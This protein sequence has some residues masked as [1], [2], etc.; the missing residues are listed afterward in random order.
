[1]PASPSAIF[2]RARSLLSLVVRLAWG[3]S[4]VA[5][6]LGQERKQG[7]HCFHNW[8]AIALVASANLAPARAADVIS[9]ERRFNW[10]AGT[11]VGV[12]GGFW[13]YRSRTVVNITGLDNT[14]ATDVTSALQGW[15]DGAA[16]DVC[17]LLPAGTFRLNSGINIGIKS[18]NTGKKRITLRGAGMGQTILMCYGGG[19]S[20]AGGGGWPTNYPTAAY[21]SADC[22]AGSTTMT[23]PGNECFVGSLLN[24]EGIA[25]PTVPVWMFGEEAVRPT[26]LLCT[27]VSGDTV[28][29]SPAMP[30]A[31]KAGTRFTRELGTG[32]PHYTTHTY[33]C[34]LEDLTVD[35]ANS[36]AGSIVYMGMAR[37]CWIYNVEAKSFYNYGISAT[38]TMFCSIVHTVVRDQQDNYPSV[39]SRNGCLLT[40]ST[41]LLYADNIAFNMVSAMEINAGMTCSA[42]VYN[43]ADR[44]SVR[45]T[46]GSAFNINHGFNN[47][48]N[49]YEG[50]IIPRIQPDGYFGF[51][52]FETI[53]R[54]WIHGTNGVYTT[55]WSPTGGGVTVNSNR[56]PVTLNRGSRYFNVV[57]NILGRT[58]Q[59][60]TWDTTNAG[61]GFSGTSTTSVNLTGIIGTEPSFT[62]QTG[63]KYNDNGTAAILYSAA[64]PTKWV[65]GS[66]RSYNSG[67]GTFYLESV[68]RA[69]GS[70]T[71]NDWVMVGGGGYGND[72]IYTLGGPNIGNGGLLFRYG[73][74]VAP[75][76]RG[77]W[78]PSYDGRTFIQRGAF[79]GATTYNMSGS[80]I[81]GT[82]DTVT[83]TAN[84][85][86]IYGGNGVSRWSAANPA[87]AGTA[88]WATPGPE[89][90]DWVPHGNNVYQELDYDVYGTGIFKLNWSAPYAGYPPT[91][92]SSDTV[93]TSYLYTSK[94]GY[95]GDRSW[96]VF[97]SSTGDRSFTA[98]GAGYRYNFFKTNGT[99]VG[100]EVTGYSA[101]DSGSA[102]PAA[103][104]HTPSK[105]RTLRR[106]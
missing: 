12:P 36:S 98:N 100:S 96:P 56:L 81:G 41:G 82:T 5:Q 57:G 16:D 3:R 19:V 80:G 7:F 34:G 17:L 4:R 104:T 102:P 37:E 53:S 75:Q 1:M 42:F 30:Y 9:S 22:V 84:S 87:K 44:I 10:Q 46:V 93:A 32:S 33:R 6:K 38:S 65:L 47:S 48:F 24:I 35:G 85:P 88:T 99:W 90:T 68:Q 67:T 72:T 71:V 45:E 21:L 23:V 77:I 106:R 60:I 94:P 39:S 58:D 27:A 83:Y 70:G 2:L 49:L 73:G 31:I 95:L 13:Q 79:N 51:S 78:W 29:F 97:D 50:N 63:L 92:T 8:I 40:F 54:N 91:E 66:V 28:T 43:I 89:Q 61:P 74:I 26:L 52:Q 14:G 11:N 62:T 59:G 86:Y 64:D 101:D 18:D 25:D 105:L 55:D 76:T 103:P 20:I 69:N 15:I